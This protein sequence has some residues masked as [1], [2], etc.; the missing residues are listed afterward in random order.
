MFGAKVSNKPP[1]ILRQ[2]KERDRSDE[3]FLS[4]AVSAL[5][6]SFKTLDVT[7]Q[8][9]EKGV[10]NRSNRVIANALRE[11][12][13]R[14]ADQVW[15]QMALDLVVNCDSSDESDTEE[16]S[17]RGRSEGVKALKMSDAALLEGLSQRPR[18]PVLGKFN[19]TDPDIENLCRN[20][21]KQL[22]SCGPAKPSRGASAMT[23]PSSAPQLKRQPNGAKSK[24]NNQP[25]QRF[26]QPTLHRTKG[27]GLDGR[28]SRPGSAPGAPQVGFG[29]SRAVGRTLHESMSLPAGITLHATCRKVVPSNALVSSECAKRI[30]QWSKMHDSNTSWSRNERFPATHRKTNAQVRSELLSE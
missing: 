24:V 17:V 6:A 2:I 16:S 25:A 26:Q 9:L 14:E 27:G 11:S 12:E 29:D 28:C 13:V 20:L 22:D 15:L 18:P 1:A 21:A 10:S 19:F 4:E 7:R 5:R 23:R 30:P 8:R 3:V